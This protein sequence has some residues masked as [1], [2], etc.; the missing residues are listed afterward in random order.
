MAEK[1]LVNDAAET[2]GVAPPEAAADDEELAVVLELEDELPQ[3]AI[4]AAA[5][6]AGT[7][8]H[9]PTDISMPPLNTRAPDG[10]P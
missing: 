10:A 6:N 7:M 2:V 4:T 1:S 5:A 8:A 3:P 9:F